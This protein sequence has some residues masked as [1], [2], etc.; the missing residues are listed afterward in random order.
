V[1]V[2]RDL[3]NFPVTY[4]FAENDQR[5]SL[6]LAMPYLIQLAE[7]GRDPGTPAR[8]RVRAA[9]LH[10]A[11][12]DFAATISTRHPW[13]ALGG[14]DREP[15]SVRTRPWLRPGRHAGGSTTTPAIGQRAHRILL[16]TVGGDA[17]R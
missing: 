14:N 12:D 11:V 5:F 1:A 3:V 6:A 13:R 15:R 17:E 9:V 7:H 8:V 16:P 4:Y 2:E 10:D